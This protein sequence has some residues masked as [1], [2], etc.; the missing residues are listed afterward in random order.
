MVLTYQT[1]SD[2]VLENFTYL[3][4][5]F[6]FSVIEKKQFTVMKYIE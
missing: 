5:H 3:F 6:I 4:N 1:I 2:F